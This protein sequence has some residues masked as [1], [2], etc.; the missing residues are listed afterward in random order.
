MHRSRGK[1]LCVNNRPAAAVKEFTKLLKMAPEDPYAFFERALAYRMT[2]QAAK[3]VVDFQKAYDFG[4]KNNT[5]L[6]YNRGMA[7]LEADKA[8]AALSDFHRALAIHPGYRPALR[9]RAAAYSRMG[10]PKAALKDCAEV[11]RDDPTDSEAFFLKGLALARA[12]KG[13]KAKEAFDSAL[14]WNS[15]YIA[16]LHHRGLTLRDLKKPKDASLDFTKVITL[17]ENASAKEDR[18]A[19]LRAQ[20]RLL[21]TVLMCRASAFYT[22]HSSDKALKDYVY[23]KKLKE[24]FGLPDVFVDPSAKKK[25]RKKTKA[26]SKK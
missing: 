18:P 25:K 17:L 19:M 20:R 1:W 21:Y 6:F 11:L 3:A 12:G 5:D 15:N 23:A 10:Q 24:S 16:A 9:G 13:P 4:L 7:M 14:Q 26:E 22:L 8:G 2:G